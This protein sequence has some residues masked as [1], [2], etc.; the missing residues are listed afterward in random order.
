MDADRTIDMDMCLDRHSFG[1]G[2]ACGY[3][4]AQGYAHMCIQGQRYAQT[5]EERNAHVQIHGY[6]LK[7]GSGQGYGNEKE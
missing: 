2:H 7:Y 3:G 1:Y 6:E 4:H 5:C